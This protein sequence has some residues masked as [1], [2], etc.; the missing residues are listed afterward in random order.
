MSF[1]INTGKLSSF[2]YFVHP[3]I[4]LVLSNFLF[5][6]TWLYVATC[7]VST[8]IGVILIKMDNKKINMLL[9]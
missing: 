4:I 3:L 7:F 2:I 6:E 8:L 9:F 1:K 5:K